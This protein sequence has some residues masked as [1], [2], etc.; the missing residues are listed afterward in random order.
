M[1]KSDW[2]H[3]PLLRTDTECARRE[4]EW[5]RERERDSF[6]A[7]CEW[8]P[9]PVLSLSGVYGHLPRLSLSNLALLCLP[10]FVRWKQMSAVSSHRVLVQWGDGRS[11]P[12][13][14]ACIVS[15]TQAGW[16]IRRNG[17]QIPWRARKVTMP[18]SAAVIGGTYDELY[19]RQGFFFLLALKWGCTREDCRFTMWTQME[20]WYHVRSVGGCFCTRTAQKHKADVTADTSS[21]PLRNTKKRCRPEDVTTRH[22][23]SV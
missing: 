23:I 11:E 19:T 12:R 15:S 9:S 2:A 22:M 4:R 10:A 21:S 1:G 14:L 17:W 16:W 20:F 6:P 18:T 13:L 5:D 8:T 7:H 3:Y